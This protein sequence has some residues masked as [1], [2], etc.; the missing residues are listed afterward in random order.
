MSD[1]IP[2]VAEKPTLYACISVGV[3]H[4][5]LITHNQERSLWVKLEAM[6]GHHE[7]TNPYHP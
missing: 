1:G 4:S 7:L 3:C 2:G 6:S 5:E